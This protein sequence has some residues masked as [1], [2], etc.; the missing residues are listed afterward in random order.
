MRTWDQLTSEEQEEKITAHIDMELDRDWWSSTTTYIEEVLA[1]MFGVDIAVRGFDLG[2]GRGVS[3]SARY[4]VRVRK[5]LGVPK[6]LLEVMS[7]YPTD[8]ELH[9]FMAMAHAM[10]NETPLLALAIDPVTGLYTGTHVEPVEYYESDDDDEVICPTV[11]ELKAFRD[12]LREWV[13][14][15]LQAEYDYVTSREATREYLQD[16]EFED[17]EEE[18][19]ATTD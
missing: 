10:F 13:L 19:D 9:T 3:L 8:T 17:A 18:E 7:A 15:H 2:R 1:E 6:D 14:T 16:M 12:A 5:E 4:P 11:D